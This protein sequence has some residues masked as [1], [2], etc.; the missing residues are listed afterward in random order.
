MYFS[1]QL[2]SGKESRE[3]ALLTL[4]VMEL[5]RHRAYLAGSGWDGPCRCSS[6]AVLSEAEASKAKHEASQIGC[7][8]PEPAYMWLS[9][10]D[11]L[12]F[13]RPTTLPVFLTTQVTS[14]FA[15]LPFPL[16][17]SEVE[18][19][20]HTWISSPITGETWKND[21]ILL[22]SKTAQ[23]SLDTSVY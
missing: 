17:A 11:S 7:R 13:T 3:R 4:Q 1:A 23:V 22:G 6:R 5:K 16:T 19:G 2:P 10:L 21:C 15:S 12:L 8:H 9:V 18:G 14:S 20:K